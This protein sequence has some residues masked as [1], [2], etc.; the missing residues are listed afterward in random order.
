MSASY[1]IHYINNWTYILS[2]WHDYNIFTDARAKLSMQSAVAKARG[3]TAQTRYPQTETVL[4]EVMT[5]GQQDLGDE[6]IFG[7]CLIIT[8]IIETCTNLCTL[9]TITLSK[10]TFWIIYFSLNVKTGDAL[11]ETGEVFKQLAEIKDNLVS[12]WLQLWT[13]WTMI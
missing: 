1:K 2:T 12:A 5:K 9:S 11:G 13:I 3:H 6:S 7:M 10:K 4:G 8:E